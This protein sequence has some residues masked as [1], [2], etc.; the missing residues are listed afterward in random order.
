MSNLSI[1]DR[2]VAHFQYKGEDI[3]SL[4]INSQVIIIGRSAFAS[5]N[6]KEIVF[7]KDSS[8]EK[9]F[10]FAFHDCK[11]LKEITF[12]ATINR[13][14]NNAFEGCSSLKKVRIPK[15]IR[16]IGNKAFKGISNNAV[17]EYY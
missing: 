11:H 9:I 1:R 6:L 13:I 10:A 12:P 2:R 8:L 14:G 15:T 16:S 5:T 7:D 17:I 3:E 4:L